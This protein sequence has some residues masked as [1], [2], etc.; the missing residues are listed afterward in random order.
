MST[1]VNVGPAIAVGVLALVALTIAS[2]ISF[3]D[4][5]INQTLSTSLTQAPPPAA[6]PQ[7]AGFAA[8]VT[9]VI[10][11]QLAASRTVP[12]IEERLSKWLSKKASA[13]RTVAIQYSQHISTEAA[14]ASLANT[15][16]EIITP[17]RIAKLAT[18]VSPKD[19]DALFQPDRMQEA[20]RRTF[21]ELLATKD[22]VTP[23]EFTELDPRDIEKETQLST[24]LAEHLTKGLESLRTNAYEAI[25]PLER[26]DELARIVQ[27][28]E[29][30]SRERAVQI[31]WAVTA[32]LFT[33]SV[34]HA[35]FTSAS[36]IFQSVSTPQSR[37]PGP[38][39]SAWCWRPRASQRLSCSCP[40]ANGSVPVSGGPFWRR[41]R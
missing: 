3:D 11:E 13:R 6:S 19:F 41:S 39:P 35:L 31:S 22:F 40:Q 1:L 29:G 24:T 36:A 4:P 12:V 38:D 23:M 17:A 18:P 15:V 27:M 25:K 7:R 37:P 9:K 20:L 16:M 33:L 10:A 5:P 2:P 8:A 26:P 32:F 21:S 28:I 34:L 14:R 30:A